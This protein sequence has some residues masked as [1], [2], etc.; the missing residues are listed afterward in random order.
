LNTSSSSSS[1]RSDP[2]GAAAEGIR[3]EDVEVNAAEVVSDAENVAAK[4]SSAD[5]SI[6]S[7][8]SSGEE[9]VV[10]GTSTEEDEVSMDELKAAEETV[11]EHATVGVVTNVERVV[12]TTPITITSSG[13]TPQGN[14]SE[15]GSHV[16]PSVFDSS[17]STCHYVRRA[18]RGSIVSTDSESTISTTV[19]VPTPPSLCTGL[20]VLP[21]HL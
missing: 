16:D 18:R 3:G 13:G 21:L 12:E 19:R 17:P 7:S 14:P 10:A 6:A 2:S 8:T 9:D 20:V 5:E 11:E 15:S 1:D 4:V